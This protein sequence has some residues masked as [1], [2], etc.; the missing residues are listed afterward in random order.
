M[1]VVVLGRAG[2]IN[3]GVVKELVRLSPD[4]DVVIADRNVEKGRNLPESL[5]AGF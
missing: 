2:H 3:S 4:L 5:E 1:T